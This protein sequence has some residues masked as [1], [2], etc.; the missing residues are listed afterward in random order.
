MIPAFDPNR[1][2]GGEN[3]RKN[4]LRSDTSL[5][6]V[7]IRRGDF[8][9]PGTAPDYRSTG[10]NTLHSG[11]AGGGRTF[12]EPAG[13]IRIVRNRVGAGVIFRRTDGFF[14]QARLAVYAILYRCHCDTGAIYDA[15]TATVDPTFWIDHYAVRRSHG[16]FPAHARQYFCFTRGVADFNHCMAY[17][18]ES[19]EHSASARGLHND[20]GHDLSVYL[21]AVNLGG[22]YVL[23][24]Q[25]PYCGASP[26]FNRTADSGC[27]RRNAIK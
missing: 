3:L 17:L 15:R 13:A 21:F 20:F 27:Q 5:G 25:E 8:T 22:G 7:P 11:L 26:F 6:A 10:E 4:V 14:H 12:T 16:A 19:L 23:I 2:R 18:A 1:A 24:A 9:A